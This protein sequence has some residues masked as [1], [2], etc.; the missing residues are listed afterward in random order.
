MAELSFMTNESQISMI[1]PE[2]AT[3][4]N[5]FAPVPACQ[6]EGRELAGGVLT[7]CAGT[8]VDTEVSVISRGI[9]FEALAG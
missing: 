1:L 3:S 2:G 4:V 5:K 6:K 8:A 9:G 7:T